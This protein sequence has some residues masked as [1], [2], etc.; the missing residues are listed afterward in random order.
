MEAASRC[1]V[2]FD[3]PRS[4]FRDNIEIIF[5]I[6]N[7][8]RQSLPCHITHLTNWILIGAM[9]MIENSI[10]TARTKNRLEQI[11]S[12]VYSNIN[13]LDFIKLFR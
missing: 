1:A 2:L 7:K 6:D 13:F 3:I 8:R 11:L 12:H 9:S 4:Y 10:E 5:K